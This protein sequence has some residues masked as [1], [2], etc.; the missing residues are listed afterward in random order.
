[1]K[2]IFLIVVFISSI[3]NANDISLLDIKTLIVQNGKAIEQNGKKIELMEMK[4]ELTKKEID[5]RFDFLQNI[6]YL[7][8]AAVFGVPLY[9]DSR[10]SKNDE[11]LAKAKDKIKEITLVLKELAQDDPKIK[12]SID[13]VGL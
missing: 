10:R 4:L 11:E 6:V 5:K 2:K 1:M 3:T 13:M 7:V 8:L 12:R 9:L